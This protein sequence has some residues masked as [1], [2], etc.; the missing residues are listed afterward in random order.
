MAALTQN[1]DLNILK[2]F[3]SLKKLP[4][5]LHEVVVAYCCYNFINQEEEKQL[6]EL[7]RFLDHDNKNR[8]TMNDF[9]KGFKDANILITTFE[10]K[11]IINILDSDGNNSIEYQE[12]LRAACAKELLFKEENLKAVFAVIDKDKKGYAD[13][14]DIKRFVLG[15]KKINHRKI[16][17]YLLNL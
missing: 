14:D 10:L 17:Y 15:E 13:A 11:K 6:R 9:I 4:S 3:I 7:F 5:K 1:K 16:C 8:L 12:F 2:R